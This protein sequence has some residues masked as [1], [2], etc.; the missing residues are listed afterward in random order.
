MTLDPSAN[1]ASKSAD[2]TDN[3]AN[4]RRDEAAA[5]NRPTDDASIDASRRPIHTPE[6]MAVSPQIRGFIDVIDGRRIGGWAFRTGQPEQ[7]I[8]VEIRRDDQTL[9]TIRADKYRVD[10]H[11]LG[12]GTGRHGFEVI[13]DDPIP[14]DQRDRITAHARLDDTAELTALPN[15]PRRGY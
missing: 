10:L 8:E 13:V 6:A 1:T 5:G 9:A 15:A 2:D 7:P 12:I 3:A 4:N 11:R 14:S